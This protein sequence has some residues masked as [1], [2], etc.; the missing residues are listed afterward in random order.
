MPARTSSGE[1]ATLLYASVK[2]LAA[3]SLPLEVVPCQKPSK[4]A[5]TYCS[6][7]KPW[8]ACMPACPVPPLCHCR[9]N[10]C[11]VT[12]SCMDMMLEVIDHSLVQLFR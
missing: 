5:A 2:R 1:D 11:K 3:S 4:R 8:L 9:T 10:A 12:D 7:L 6:Y